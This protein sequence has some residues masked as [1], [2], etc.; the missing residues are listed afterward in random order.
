MYEE[1]VSGLWADGTIVFMIAAA[2]V[3][4]GVGV[5]LQWDIWRD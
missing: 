3:I 5:L 2:L 1:I 4:I